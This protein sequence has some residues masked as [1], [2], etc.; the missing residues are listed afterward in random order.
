MDKE[1]RDLLRL[2]EAD[3]VKDTFTHITTYGPQSKWNIKHQNLETF[4][5]KYCELVHNKLESKDYCANM[6]LC[7]KPQDVSPLNAKFTFRFHINEDE[8][9]W[10]PYDD[11]FLHWICYI[12]QQVLEDNFRINS[13][14]QMEFIVV[15]MESLSHW[16][17][18]SGDGK[19]FLVMEMKIQ[20]PY[21]RIESGLQYRVVRSKV[22]NLL[23]EH[24]VMSKMNR[25]PIGD[26]DNIIS[27]STNEPIPLY[28]SSELQSKPKLEIIH[29]WHI[30][31]EHMLENSLQPEDLELESIF[32]PTMHHHV[33]MS[34]VSDTIFEDIGDLKFWLPMFL[35]SYYWEQV[36]MP[37]MEIPNP[38][39]PSNSKILVNNPERLLGT[40]FNG[41]SLKVDN[42]NEITNIEISEQMIKMLKPFRFFRESF[43]LD[44]GKAL[45]WSDDG[46]ENG[47][48]SWIRHSEK[49][50]YGL[51]EEQIP[52][53]LLS[54][55]SIAETCKS[56]YDTFVNA[57]ITVKTLAWYARED[58][59]EHYDAWHFDW[60][61]P[62]INQALER[63]DNDVAHA[64][65]KVYW[66][67]YVYCA[68]G[69][70]K[71]FKFNKQRWY[72]INQGL[73][74]TKEL[75]YGFRKIFELR[76][77]ILTNQIHQSDDEGFISNGEIAIKKLT[78][79]I[80]KLKM[81]PFKNRILE[82]SRE[83]FNND[84][85]ISLLDTN[86][87]LTGILNGVIEANEHINFRN[88][89]PEDYIS[90][91][92][93]IPYHEDYSF[94][95]PLVKELME[96]MSKCFV[97][98]SLRHHFLK[99]SAS[100]LKGGN[101]DKIF[102]IWTGEGNNSKS[103]IVKL[104]E[105]T[106]AS[107]CIK[108][109]VSM[110]SEK[111]MNSS[112]PTPQLARARNTRVAF[113]DEPEDDLPMH[114]GT[115]KRY[116]G[117]D[118]F[119]ARLL[120]DNGGDIKA[121][122]TMV[123]MCNKVPNIDKAD[124]AVHN[125]TKIFP[126]LSTWVE[127]PPETE[128]EQYRKLLFKMDKF[129]E[130]RIPIL[131]PAFLWVMVQYYSY[132]KLEGLVDP[133]IITEYTENYWRENDLV[134]LYIADNIQYDLING[135][136]NPNTKATLREIWTNFKIWFKENFPSSRPPQRDYLKSELINRWGKMEG[137]YWRG[138]ILISDEEPTTFSSVSSIPHKPITQEDKLAEA[139]RLIETIDISDIKLNEV[140]NSQQTSQPDI[141][142]FQNEFTTI[143]I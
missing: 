93:G 120:Q 75:S 126:Y 111:A 29:I 121:T 71:W 26:W 132:Y 86:L 58:S 110:L 6:C 19:R 46:G 45:Y 73:E 69:K 52:N 106:L 53:Y 34:A 28:G 141:L 118:S 64:F 138:I 5:I 51:P 103:M 43:W 11:D 83:F 2:L 134:S 54:A 102:P 57:N 35:S 68:E 3:D 108:L 59:P 42:S 13:E 41:S 63:T 89:K 8:E 24:N 15:V 137:N 9:A 37:K 127:N 84:K 55:G 94:E 95:H 98:R 25:Q 62:S 80:H 91:C 99:F 131:A 38:L 47:L 104:F 66:L 112:G 1:L 100:F 115:I 67:D 142:A 70:G 114:K 31:T 39:N 139:K 27:K 85:F 22:M 60:C 7:E 88:A 87:E 20:F 76:R 129:F 81:K 48:L 33:Q 107:Y 117:G 124:K 97:D 128:E 79:L 40:N 116:T 18:D 122:F 78:D 77:A 135:E 105:T 74:L 119:F 50:I 125:R 96:W 17:E 16:Y 92:T 136:P 72:E 30:I 10:E 140:Q 82:E 130:K 90:K 109:P 133:D 36:L 101:N 143:S 12:Y 14:N 56:L 32:M 23:R 123:L 61:L 21:A 44:I 49:S 4:W 113:L 65:Y